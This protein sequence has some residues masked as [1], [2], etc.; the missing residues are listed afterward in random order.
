MTSAIPIPSTRMDGLARTTPGLLPD[1]SRY[2]TTYRRVRLECRLTTRLLNP[3]ERYPR[4]GAAMAVVERPPLDLDA[5]VAA[6]TEEVV[7]AFTG[8]LRFRPI[9][10]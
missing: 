9:F 1:D 2:R 3:I 5:F 4:C 7:T 6:A 8:L 10:E